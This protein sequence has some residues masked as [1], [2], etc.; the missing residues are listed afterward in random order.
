MVSLETV[1]AIWGNADHIGTPLQVCRCDPHVRCAPA[2]LTCLMLCRHP[3]TA[4]FPL[5][6][7]RTASRGQVR[8]V[9]G[10]TAAIRLGLDSMLQANLINA[11]MTG[12]LTG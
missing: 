6:G 10:F 12:Q 11:N 1:V 4:A 8:P 3:S 7:R 2:S 5:L 9:I